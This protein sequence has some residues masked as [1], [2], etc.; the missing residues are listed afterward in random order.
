MSRPIF[1]FITLICIL[2]SFV[3]ISHTKDSN[4]QN[5]KK[6]NSQTSGATASGIKKIQI[7]KKATVFGWSDTVEAKLEA[8]TSS[9]KLYY[10]ENYAACPC[11]D[12]YVLPALP[13]PIPGCTVYKVEN[14]DSNHEP[15]CKTTDSNAKNNINNRGKKNCHN[16]AKYKINHQIVSLVI[17]FNCQAENS[18]NDD[19]KEAYSVT[20]KYI[21]RGKFKV[22]SSTKLS[23]KNNVD[24]NFQIYNKN[25]KQGLA[26]IKPKKGLEFHFFW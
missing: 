18:C 24:R 10:P 4:A 11:E 13:D 7:K 12:A 1:F 15:V 8:G 20:L 25:K 3:Q 16:Y 23:C 6:K 5:V 9:R 2:S 22:F 14:L 17:T 21:E 26:V 19:S